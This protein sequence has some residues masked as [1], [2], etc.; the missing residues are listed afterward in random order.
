MGHSGYHSPQKW[1]GSTDRSSVVF[2]GYASNCSMLKFHVLEQW[3]RKCWKQLHIY[4]IAKSMKFQHIQQYDIEIIQHVEIPCFLLS[5][6]YLTQFLGL[7]CRGATE[8]GLVVHGFQL[9]R[10]RISLGPLWWDL[11]C[12]RRGFSGHCCHLKFT[13][14]TWFSYESYDSV[15]CKT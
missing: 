12:K 2:F 5:F 11:G 7:T 3:H 1:V 4:V 8:L 6:W 15:D 13:N 14:A 10:Q 9:G